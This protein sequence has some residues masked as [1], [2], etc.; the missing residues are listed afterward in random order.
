M[1]YKLIL[2]ITVIITVV[3][4]FYFLM[5]GSMKINL[6][7]TLEILFYGKES[8]SR[9][10]LLD[11]R[12]PRIVMSILVGMLL[13][14]S[15]AVTQTVFHNPLADPYIIGISASATFGAVL[16]YVL[17]LPETFYGVLGFLCSL[18][19]SIII[20][21]ISNFTSKSNVSNLLIV[22]IAIS[23][24]LGAFTSFAV[25]L[26]GEDSFKI[27]MWT[28]G[29]LGYASWSK[30]SILVFPLLFSSGYFYIKRYELDVLLCSEE[31]AFAMGIDTK[32]LKLKLLVISSLIVGFSVAFTGMIGFVGVI[33][34]HIVR[35]I[36]KNSNRRV[37]PLAM[38]LGG[39]FLLI[40]DTIARTL[41]EPTEIPIGVV[42]AFLGA[43]FFLFLAFR[44]RKI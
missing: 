13:A 24:L 7:E 37:I 6:K 22:G 4:S 12:L 44:R 39:L 26:I 5:L 43:P 21:K 8:M 28:M 41:L 29:Y 9:I 34:P 11:I 10:I 17:N 25:Y 20:F 1:K 18:I 42:T 32:K 40:S 27:I 23:A 19:V 36:V 33:I 3:A 15:G 31:E 38:V 16:A 30:I 35:L 14:S 2:A